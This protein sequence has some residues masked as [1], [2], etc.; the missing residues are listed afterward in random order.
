MK[1]VE[2]NARMKMVAELLHDHRAQHGLC[3]VQGNR[4]DDAQRGKHEREDA[5]DPHEPQ[6]PAAGL[7]TLSRHAHPSPPSFSQGQLEPE[8]ATRC[9]RLMRINDSS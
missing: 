7:C 5:A 4:D 8:T 1:A 3:T 9:N 6:M 2:L